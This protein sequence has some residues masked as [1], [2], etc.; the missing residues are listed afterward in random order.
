MIEQ[1]NPISFF[2]IDIKYREI[3]PPQEV[4]PKGVNGID[5]E[6]LNGYVQLIAD[7]NGRHQ[8][9]TSANDLIK[10]LHYKPYRGQH[11]FFYN[12][13]FDFDAIVK[14]LPD[15]AIIQLA[16]EGETWYKGYKIDYI[17]KKMFSVSKSKHTTRF[18]DVSQF[19]E[20]SLENAAYKY[21][22]QV[23][24]PD[25]LDRARI[26]TDPQ[27]WEENLDKIIKY[28]VIDCELTAKLGEVVQQTFSDDIGFIP[29]AYI[30]KAGIS[31]QYFRA[32]CIIPNIAGV[33]E[34]ALFFAHNSYYGGRFEVL[35][36][37]NLGD[38]T[39]IDINSAYPYII[40][41]LIDC[42]AGTWRLTEN[43]HEEAYY[44]FYRARLSVPPAQF[45]PLPFRLQNGT[46]CYPA[47][48]WVGFI[49]KQEIE[50]Y[51]DFLDFEII[52]GYEFYPDTIR[53]PFRE[54]INTLYE[55]KQNT[56][57]EHFRYRL[58]KIL[59]NSLYGTMYEKIKPFNAEKYRAGVLFNPIYASLITASARIQVF[60]E[61]LRYPQEDVLAFAT[62]S[63]LIRG[64]VKA[65]KVDDLG[66]FS[67]DSYGPATVLRAGV[68]EIGGKIKARGIKRVER[69]NTK[70]G[71]F[72]DIFD[73]MKQRPDLTK[74]TIISNRPLHLK[75]CVTHTKTKS[76][77]DIN[78]FTDQEY[79]IDIN[80]D[81]KRVWLDS[82]AGG[83]QVFES[84]ISSLP[85]ILT[86]DFA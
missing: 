48:E 60:T 35:E 44:G 5:T 34:E 70:H 64:K 78:I 52:R 2:D 57:K 13:Q 61:A 51:K 50:A 38:C 6:T 12:I 82:W 62:D 63:L 29:K 53:Y 3:K 21:L 39:L 31:K 54:A 47:G 42:T 7:Q 84:S 16:T 68:Y 41:N 24:N 86:E 45:C 80:T 17:P 36:K 4:D 28:C 15:D 59:M 18:Y 81:F 56:P 55:Q 22:N 65:P 11:N 73:Y 83:G 58:Y 72:N 40:A 49:T 43:Y 85:I 1:F 32:N 77:R 20:T 25:G 37:G 23:K 27:Y 26:G 46:I 9:I 66:A 75:E 14:W 76:I 8:I 67:F 74:Y 19:F 79:D 69:L 10:W 71:Q 33:P 30:S